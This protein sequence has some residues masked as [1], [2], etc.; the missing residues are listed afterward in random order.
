[1]TVRLGLLLAF[2]LAT[3]VFQRVLGFFSGSSGFSP[4]PRVFLLV[5]RFSP[6]A[7]NQHSQF[8]FDLETVDEK[9]HRV[10]CPLLNSLVN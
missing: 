5:L 3:R 7:K 9:S 6:S 10:E 8:Q 4:G 1:M 2:V